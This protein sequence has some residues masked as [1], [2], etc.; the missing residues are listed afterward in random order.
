MLGGVLLGLAACPHLL[1][2]HQCLGRKP[3]RFKLHNGDIR[4]P[5]GSKLA[6]NFDDSAIH[7]RTLAVIRPRERSEAARPPGQIFRRLKIGSGT[8]LMIIM[9]KRQK[10]GT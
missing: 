10:P 8:L 5:G 7:P 1:E 6:E 2:R 9:M 4:S 3:R